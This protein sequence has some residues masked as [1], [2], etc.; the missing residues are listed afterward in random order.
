MN[1]EEISADY[2]DFVNNSMD[3]KLLLIELGVGL[4]YLASYTGRLKELYQSILMLPL[5]E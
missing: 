5:S 3:G 1:K 4:T 2:M